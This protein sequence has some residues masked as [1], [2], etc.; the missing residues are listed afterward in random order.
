MASRFHP[1]V[2]DAGAEDD[3]VTGDEDHGLALGEI[4]AG[5]RTSSAVDVART[6]FGFSYAEVFEHN[7]NI[8]KNMGVKLPGQLCDLAAGHGEDG[9]G[10]D[11]IDA[12]PPRRPEISGDLRHGI[13][14]E[15]LPK[16]RL[17]PC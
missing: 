14:P 15:G 2:H 12:T 11:K 5:Q 8:P 9:G 16:S 6:K 3:R 17:T 7:P 4:E 10:L 1:A 13:P